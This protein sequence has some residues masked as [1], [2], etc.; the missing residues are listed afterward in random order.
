VRRA[1]EILKL[2]LRLYL[3]QIF[4]FLAIWLGSYYP[5]LDTLLVLL[6]LI[7]LSMEARLSCKYNRSKKLLIILYW[8]GP[9][10]LLSL[11]IAGD[12][13]IKILSQNAIFMLEFWSTPLLPLIV[14]FAEINYP[15]RPL[16]YF[17]ILAS[18]VIVGIYYYILSCRN[19]DSYNNKTSA[20]CFKN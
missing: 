6:Y 7:L 20:G 8:Q 13:Y 16:Y 18:P 17:V 14:P 10:V 12:F 19:K 9:A 5:G 11:I 4:A 3:L 2:V 1:D 15:N